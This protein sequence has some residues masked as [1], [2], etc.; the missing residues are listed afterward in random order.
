MQRVKVSSKGQNRYD[1]SPFD[2]WVGC[3]KHLQGRTTD[4]LIEE[5]RGPPFWEGTLLPEEDATE[6]A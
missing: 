5:M 1:E 3:L 4:E 2:K 6:S